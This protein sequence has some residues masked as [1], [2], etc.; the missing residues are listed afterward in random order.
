[1][2]RENRKVKTVIPLTR[3][4]RLCDVAGFEFI[5]A[6]KKIKKE[7]GKDFC[8]YREGRGQPD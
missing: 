2:K 7:K 1:M 4:Q 5:D 8:D 6:G 3:D